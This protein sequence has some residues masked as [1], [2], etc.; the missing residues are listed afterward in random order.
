ML[1]LWYF[2]A[3]RQPGIAAFAELASSA[4]DT[5]QFATNAVTRTKLRKY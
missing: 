5:L 4:N 2:S 1:G 3:S